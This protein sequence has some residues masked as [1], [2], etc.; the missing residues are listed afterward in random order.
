MADEPRLRLAP[1][2]KSSL[3]SV[4]ARRNPCNLPVVPTEIPTKPVIPDHELLRMIGRGSYGEVWL[5]RSVMGSWR[6]VKVIHR[7]SFEHERPFER[8]FAGIKRYE[9][10]S[11]SHEGL[12]QVLHVGR[13]PDFSYFYYVM[14]LADDVSGGST[15]DADNYIPQ[16]LSR[17][18][19]QAITP[20]QCVSIGLSLAAALGQLHQGGLIHRDVKPSNIILVHGRPKLADIG[21]VAEFGES[22]S[23]VGT[24]GFI[25]PEGTGTPQADIFALGKVLYEISTGL[26]RNEFPK[27]PRAWLEAASPNRT[28]LEL[29]EVVLKACEANSARRHQSAAEVQAELALIQVG[30]SVRRIRFVE[31]RLKWATRLGAAAVV[32]GLAAIAFSVLA[33]RQAARDRNNLQRIERAEKQMREQLAHSLLAEARARRRSPEAGRRFE[34]LETIRRAAAIQPSLEL[35]NELIAALACI[36]FRLVRD[37]AEFKATRQVMTFDPT[38]KRYAV[39]KTNG[40]ISIRDV[41]NDLELG[42]LPGQGGRVRFYL[43][44]SPDARWLCAYHEDRHL[45]VWDWERRK[46]VLDLPAGDNLMFDVT[47]DSRELILRRGSGRLKFYH[48]EEGTLSRELSFNTNYS[49]WKLAPDGKRIALGNGRTVEVRA[50]ED[51]SLSSS[52]EAGNEVRRIEWSAD[53]SLLAVARADGRIQVF[54]PN[55]GAEQLSISGH[56]GPALVVAF[57][58]AGGWI[59][60]SSWDG[61]T[62]LWDPITGEQALTMNRAGQSIQFSADGRMGVENFTS[63]GLELFEAALPKHPAIFVPQARS[64]PLQQSI[65]FSPDGQSLCLASDD[66]VR[67]WGADSKVETQFIPFSRVVRSALFTPDGAALLLSG[68]QGLFRCEAASNSHGGLHIREPQLIEPGEHG[69]AAM[70]ATG[71]FLAFIHIDHAHATNSGRSVRLAGQDD[72]TF[73][74]VSPDQKWIAGGARIKSGVTAWDA[75]TGAVRW[76]FPAQDGAQ[77]AFTTDSQWLVAGA[78][79]EYVFWNLSNGQPGVR[80]SRP[81]TAALHGVVAVSPDG[82][83]IAVNSSRSLVQLRDARTGEEIA[84]L[85]SSSRQTVSSL[86]FSPDGKRLAVAQQRETFHVWDLPA[87]RRDLAAFGLDWPDR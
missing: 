73:I 79:D 54:D 75:A 45:R 42:A 56:Q 16:T 72:L 12:V 74:A 59:G 65:S 80:F 18:G 64:T 53:G 52:F 62:R 55:S 8:E 41:A 63:S 38:L 24:E 32:L 36:D 17:G 86:A 34:T 85:E 33:Q 76:Q 35:R 5:A 29:N 3:G 23:I 15:I 9:P 10:I 44:F 31:R 69:R 71:N 22:R 84:T 82:K 78:S 49:A 87:L 68:E 27:L 14:E 57:L 21:L 46:L 25:P 19:A 40:D 4:T 67:L 51:Q 60:S 83:L 7:A 47:P 11:R 77:V 70:S 30:R 26:D 50:L 66:G 39:G 43:Y 28:L 13:S 81:A 61:T 2:L 48:L 1:M 37:F 58:S 20:E 6:A